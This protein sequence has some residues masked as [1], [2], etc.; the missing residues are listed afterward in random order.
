MATIT[1]EQAELLL[2]PNYA[3]AATVRDDG[4]P[5]QTVIWVDW[6]GENVVFN[7]AEGRAKPRHIRRNPHVSVHVMDPTN[8]YK[9]LSVSGRAEI[10]TEGADDHIDKLAKKYLGQD[11]YP[12]RKPTEQR[13]IVRVRPQ[14]VDAYGFE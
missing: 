3:V 9:W 12:W 7:T 6:D 13:L 10:P 14:R 4:S 2:N 8:P 5:Q 11:T 1:D